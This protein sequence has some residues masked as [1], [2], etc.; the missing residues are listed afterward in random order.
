MS[1]IL[2]TT[3]TTTSTGTSSSA[4]SAN[5]TTSTLANIGQG[6]V[7]DLGNTG[8]VTSTGLGSGLDISS[9]VTSLVNAEGQPQQTLLTNQTNQINTQISAYGQLSAGITGLE[10]ALAGLATPQQFEGTVATVGDQTIASA[11][12]DSTATVG[13]YNLLVQ[14][15]AQ[16]AQLAS[17]PVASSSTVIGTGTL[18]FQAGGTSFT[19][20][21]NSSNDTLAGIAG[22]INSAGSGA[23]ISATLQ[24]SNTGTSLIINSAATGASNALNITETDGGT[25]LAS[26]TYS[27]SSSSTPAT[28]LTQVQAAQDAIVQLNG[29]TYNSA[30][31][32]VTG[33]LTGVTLTLTGT[34]TG[35]TTTPL[36]I[37]GDTSGAETAVQTFIS[38]YNSLIGTIQ[39][40][41]SF[42]ASTG[43]AGPLLGDPLLGNL[44]NQINETIDSSATMP[45]GSPFNSLAQLGIVA[46][47][48][49]TLSANSTT[50]SNAFTNNFSAV[51][52][53]FSGTGGIATKLNN[54][55]NQF[56]QPD[57]VLATENTTLQAGLTKIA[58][59]TT[60]LNQH[61]SNL[62]ATLLQQYNAMDALVA[63]MKQ[64]STQTTAQLNSIY[65]AGE[66]NTP[67]P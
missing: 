48:D 52:Q 2:S 36:T 41:S 21:I 23:G 66:A 55:L 60:A 38:S 59:E 11:T 24:A 43:A 31:N 40:L 58:N 51:A 10:A 35:T 47:P 62:Q 67:V 39:S 18:N 15:L 45:A 61:L 7:T 4:T 26:L 25:G 49:G 1:S 14:Q 57:G 65:Y 13:N 44:V 29:S 9:I 20:T 56:T 12:T 28:G 32:V 33:L 64:T 5:S 42:D 63:Q 27:P 30:S 16:G 22:A 8:T 50:L 37:S 46:N 53:L 19:V 3:P 54:A 6:V 17:T 34:S